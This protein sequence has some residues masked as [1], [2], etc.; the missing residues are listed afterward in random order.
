MERAS[1]ITAAKAR[2][3]FK[4]RVGAGFSLNPPFKGFGMALLWFAMDE[5]ELFRL[6][7]SDTRPTPFEE[8]VDTHVGFKDASVAAIRASFGLQEKEAELLYYQMVM[9][10]LGLAHSCVEGGASLSI[11]KASQ[12]LG[13]NVRAFLMEIRAGA[14]ERESFIPRKGAGPDGDVDSYM[15]IH[16]LTGQNRLLQELHANPRYIRDNE[17]AELMRVMRNSIDLTPESIR[18]DNPGLTRGDVRLFI[19]S[20][21]QF[22]VTEQAVLLGI[23]PS[24][25]TKARQRLKARLGASY[26]L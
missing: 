26:T 3:I 22:S 4:E 14:D 16:A 21:L 19:L 17:W 6:V 9:V 23:S 12:I 1:G 20:R 10:A 2:E 13:K 25:V 8:Y 7:M 5:P 24:S 18:K 15:M 11:A